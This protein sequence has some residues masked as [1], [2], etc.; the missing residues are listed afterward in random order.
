MSQ[1]YN[2]QNPF[3]GHRSRLET[4][5]EADDS[6]GLRVEQFFST[7]GVHPFEQ[8]EWEVRSARILDESGNLTQMIEYSFDIT[9]RKRIEMAIKDSETSFVQWPNLPKTPLSPPIKLEKLP[10][11]T[12]R[13][14][15]CSATTKTSLSESPSAS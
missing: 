6:K 9:E 5:M 13:L 8:L 1:R 10:F 3:K 12:Q 11:A 14:R 4:A 7:G 2:P 15:S